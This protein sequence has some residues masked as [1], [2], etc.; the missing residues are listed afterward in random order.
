M[1]L[2]QL[3]QQQQPRLLWIRLAGPVAGSGNKVDAQRTMHLCTLV[4]AQQSLAG[5]V[6]LEANFRSQVWNMQCIRGLINGLT[7]SQHSWC[8]YE[9]PRDA[10]SNAVPCNSVVQLA[11]NFHFPSALCECETR[12]KHVDSKRLGRM[13]DCR[14]SAVLNNLVGHAIQVL[15]SGRQRRQ[16]ELKT[17]SQSETHFQNPP[18]STTSRPNLSVQLSHVPVPQFVAPAFSDNT[19]SLDDA[20]SF[21]KTCRLNGDFS[22]DTCW[23]VV[24]VTPFRSR[25]GLRDIVKSANPDG[26]SYAFGVY[27][28]G[29]FVGITRCTE[30]HPELVRYLNNCLRIRD[31]DTRWSSLNLN[32]NADMLPHKDVHN[33]TG[34]TNLIVGFGN[35]RGGKVWIEVGN[36]VQGGSNAVG[37]DV[38]GKSINGRMVMGRPHDCK[39]RVIAFPP[40]RI[41][42]PEPWEGERWTLVAFASRGVAHCSRDEL[43]K[44]CGL[45]FPVGLVPPTSHATRDVVDECRVV[46][47]ADC[48]E[49]YPTEQ[50]IKRKAVLAAG[51]KPIRRKQQVEQHRDD[52]G[53]SL[54]SIL[55][56]VEHVPWNPNFMGA[57]CECTPRESSDYSAF[58]E[59]AF[60]R[61]LWLHGSGVESP[62]WRW[63]QRP[64][65]D[66]ESLNAFHESTLRSNDGRVVAVVELFGGVG[67]TSYLIAKL[68]GL[69]AGVNFDICCGFNLSI[70]RDRELVK[71]YI[72][73]RKPLV[74]VMAPPCK[75]FG[76]LQHLN[77]VINPET[78]HRTRAEGVALA[79]F[80]AEIADMQ[81]AAGRHFVVEQP[82]G[83][84]MFALPAWEQLARKFPLVKCHF[85]QCRVGLRMSRPPH[86]PIRKPT[87]LVSSNEGF[88]V[89]R[90][91]DKQCQNDH[92]HA[93][94]TSL[95]H[96]SQHVNSSEAQVWPPMMCRLL[97]AGVADL[98]YDVVRSQPSTHS[99][100]AA[101]AKCLGCKQH[102][103]RDDPMHD[104]GP[105]CRFP[106][107]ESIDYTCPACVKRLPR[108]DAKH[109]LD[110]TCRWSLARVMQPGLSRE[111][112]GAHPRDGRVPAS[113][114]PTAELRMSSLG[115]PDVPN[116]ENPSSASGH[117]PVALPADDRDEANA[118][119]NDLAGRQ[120]SRSQAASGPSGPRRREA[121]AQVDE[122]GLGVGGLGAGARAA[123]RAAGPDGPAPEPPEPAQ[124]EAADAAAA[125]EGEGW[126]RFDVGRAL[127]ELRSHRPGVVRRALRRLHL[128][129]LHAPVARMESLLQAAGIPREVITLA[130]QIVDTCQVCRAWAKPGPRTVTTSSLPTR[131]NQVIQCDLLFIKDKVVLH[132]IDVCT[133]YTSTELVSNRNTDTLLEALQKSWFKHFGPPRGLVVDQEGGLTGPEAAA[134]F[135]AREVALEPRAKGLHADVVERHHEILRRQIHLLDSNATVEGLRA[136]FSAV[137]S[138]ATFAKNVL[139][140]QGGAS[141]YEAVYGRIP[142][143]VTVASH[144]SPDTVD[145]RDAD[146]LRHLALQSM[147]QATAEAK[148]RRADQTKTRRSG[149][150]LQLEPGDVVEFWRKASTKDIEAWHGPAVVADVTSLRDGQ[151]SVR[152]QGRVLTCRL[153]DIRRALVYVALL[154]S[155]P[156]TSPI[157]VLQEAAESHNAVVVR[158]GWFRHKGEWRAFEANSRYPKELLAGLHVAACSLSFSGT[159]SF[160]FGCNV[161]SLPGVNCDESMLLFWCPGKLEAGNFAFMAGNQHVNFAR[162]CGSTELAFVQFFAEDQESILQLRQTVVDV[163]NLG[164][165]H[166]PAM[167]VLQDVTAQVQRRAKE[168]LMLEEPQPEV[169]LP[170]VFDIATPDDATART[171]ETASETEPEQEPFF[172]TYVFSQPEVSLDPAWQSSFVVSKHELQEEPPQLLFP[173]TQ[174]H[175]LLGLRQSPKSD[176]MVVVYMSDEHQAV[177]ERVNNVLTREEALENSDRCRTSMVKEL[178]RWHAHGAWKR[179]LRSSATNLL[180][181]KWVLKWKPIGGVRDI[182]ARLVVQGFRD[183]QPVKNYAAT[184][185]RWGQRLVLI[186]AVQFGWELV[187]ADVSEAFL[188]GI[189]FAELHE[190]GVDP[191][192]RK[193]QMLLPPGAEELI[194]TI[195]GFEDFNGQQECL[196]MLK[197]GFGLKDAPRLWSLALQKVLTKIGLKAVRVDSQLFVKHAEGRLVLLVSVHVDDLKMTGVPAQIK[198][199]LSL[200][201]QAFDA[202]KIERDCFEHLG[203]RHKLLEDGSRSVDQHSYVSELRPIPEAELKLLPAEQAASQGQ[204]QQFMSLVGGLAWVVQTRP[205]VAVFVAA[206][207]RRLKAPVVK[208]LVNANRV[209]KYLKAKPLELV[210]RKIK[211]P[212]KLVVV[213]DSAFKGEDQDCL[214]MRSCVIA[215]AARE[216]LAEGEN[217]LQ[218]LEFVSKKQSK[219]CRSTFAAE[220]HSCLDAIG[221]ACVINAALTEVLGGVSSAASL[222]AKQDVG[223]HSLALDVVI[224]AKS[225]WSAVG[226]DKPECTD[227]LVLLHLCKLR[228]VVRDFVD[229][230]H[231]VD[232]RSMLSDGLTKGVIPR[233]ALR[234]VAKTGLWLIE[235][236]LETF[237]APRISENQN[238]A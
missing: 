53:D 69:K 134:W 43:S 219:V 172:S 45:D 139:F 103:R 132:T 202:L 88:I 220:L 145:D 173:S 152:W 123:A 194:R 198:Q 160:R 179:T 176:E 116:R 44:L 155:S 215:L 23:K 180:A 162:L 8:R 153:Q 55:E 47:F 51:H 195:P 131:F 114:E 122:G 216:G 231:W 238:P 206:L 144:Q 76:Q 218:I 24:R 9:S 34:S 82:A 46:S 78:W 128:R 140:N 226:N 135:E 161:S 100:F 50:A 174:S 230:F 154:V 21:A 40:D 35:Y 71:S 141:P 196:E 143:L 189:T 66:I 63:Q 77:K 183:A 97:A 235:Q 178:T 93:A 221:S 74:A 98:V 186:F 234:K 209:F 151:I 148:A 84:D 211:S 199:A 138:E 83:S 38:A 1:Y 75:G 37:N 60:G 16:P 237:K 184:T 57:A 225:V 92:E 17:H 19:M 229:Q 227:Q 188:R 149:E 217:Q 111:R 163:P 223:A 159:V 91:T 181:S 130:R 32:C 56:F 120:S 33:L 113:T 222:A 79:Q 30:Q 187:S 182:K 62:M 177:I 54:D 65:M 236:A 95:A 112:Q 224:D 156:L 165:I 3:I 28:H 124:A 214:A 228:E 26:T 59:F 146:R 166:D 213:S 108:A 129:W 7:L 106:D 48:T 107:D 58:A 136:S 118:V 119:G 171:A 158:L 39:H 109:L 102:R 73:T 49:A 64:H 18:L 96:K 205:D 192:L 15:S 94:I 204:T 89:S 31:A 157:A 167:P 207:Q 117:R 170:E 11:T 147:L 197:P 104:R 13:K 137:L 68:H 233:D 12:D 115:S 150:L 133:R 101:T 110:N 70:A 6:V 27:A 201:E 61:G 208:D 169:R 81:C 36:D 190:S 175:L 125:P 90:F 185:T 203:L 52:C 210:Y 20:E 212:W 5:V 126:S 42:C 105:G 86:L 121:G 41:H 127:Q 14:W 99:A 193:V 164:G 85:D 87:V 10:G 72:A 191:V 25:H 80:C 29:A 168:R 142:P 67:E 232:T 4:Q 22:W 200:L 2:L